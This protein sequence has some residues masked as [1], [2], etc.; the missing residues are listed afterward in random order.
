MPFFFFFYSLNYHTAI[1]KIIC[2]YSCAVL[3]KTNKQNQTVIYHNIYFPN[4]LCQYQA[5]KS[6]IFQEIIHVQV[7]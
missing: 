1:L 4:I 5:Q 3:I 6:N 7:L 2:L